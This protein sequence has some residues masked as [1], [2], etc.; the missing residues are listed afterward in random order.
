MEGSLYSSPSYNLNDFSEVFEKKSVSERFELTDKMQREFGK[1]FIVLPNAMY[2]E[3]EGALY[4]YDYS[5]SGNEK[6]N[7]RYKYLESF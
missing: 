6:S 1:R 3:W 2:G 7:I 5:I 4:N